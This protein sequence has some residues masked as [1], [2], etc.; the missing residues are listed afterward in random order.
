[1]SE[2]GNLEDLL[3]ETMDAVSRFRV[4]Q[5]EAITV[6]LDAGALLIQAKEDL[7]HGEWGS[8]LERMGLARRG[9]QRSG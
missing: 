3:L 4:G 1:M 6:A 5:R 8:W 7:Q 9:P 2:D